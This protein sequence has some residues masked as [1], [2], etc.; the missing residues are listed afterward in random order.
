MNRREFVASSL[1]AGLTGATAMPSLA[2]TEIALAEPN[3]REYYELRQYHVWRGNMANRLDDY[4]KNAYVPAMRR[5]GA[6][7][8]GVFNVMIGDDSPTVYVLTPYKTAEAALTLTSR[9]S[10]DADYRE[11][12][13]AFIDA[14]PSDPPYVHLESALLRAFET[15]PT[16]EVP[17]AAA[18]NKPRIFEL[19][20][21]KSHSKMASRKKIEMFDKGEIG[22]FRRVG[23]NPVFFGETLIGKQT[24]N[25]TYMVTYSDM[26]ARDKAFGTFIADPEWKTLSTMPEYSK[27]ELVTT[28]SSAF[29]RPAS[30]SQI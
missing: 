3:A 6:G 22:I 29:L 23:V 12:G 27:I 26:A 21:Y 9:L 25:L 7:P 20:T 11:A 18:E 17:A 4:L 19:R 24:P 1:T 16:L 15:I 2:E 30:Y 10:S 8:I 28:I 5:L 13:K 14:L